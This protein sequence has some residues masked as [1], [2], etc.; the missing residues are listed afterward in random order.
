MIEAAQ[1]LLSNFSGDVISS[2]QMSFN[3]SD[4]RIRQVLLPYCQD[5]GISVIA[6]SPLG[7]DLR[8][9]LREKDPKGFLRDL[10]RKNN[11]SVPQLIL[12]WLMDWGVIPIPRSNDPHHVAENLEALQLQLRYGDHKD[13]TRWSEKFLYNRE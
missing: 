11:C 8:R 9:E 3:F 13:L 2:V 6:Y 7:Q 5:R 12:R 4:T 1:R 10:A